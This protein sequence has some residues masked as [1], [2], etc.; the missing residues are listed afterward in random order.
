MNDM[1]VYTL[2]TYPFFEHYRSHWNSVAATM[3]ANIPFHCAV[4]LCGAAWRTRG[5]CLFYYPVHSLIILS[6]YSSL[7]SIDIFNSHIHGSSPS[8]RQV[9]SKTAEGLR[10]ATKPC[11]A[12]TQEV[13]QAWQNPHTDW[14]SRTSWMASPPSMHQ[15]FR[16][17][18][19]Y[20]MHRDQNKRRPVST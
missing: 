12:G 19:P 7:V 2:S 20:Q 6:Y 11:I 5:K 15:M 13:Q 8:L 1:C 10:V 9:K 14:S 17:Q 3:Q 18:Q 16:R 4:K